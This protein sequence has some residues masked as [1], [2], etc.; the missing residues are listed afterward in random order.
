[1]ARLA[2]N[3]GPQCLSRGFRLKL[4]CDKVFPCVSCVKR[5]LAAICPDGCLTTGQG[6]RYDSSPSSPRLEPPC[7][8]QPLFTAL[9]WHPP[10]S[11]TRKLRSC[12]IEFGLSRVRITIH[13][14]HQPTYRLSSDALR[15]AYAKLDSGPHPLLTEELLSLKSPLQRDV[16]SGGTGSLHHQPTPDKQDS[17]VEAL[18]SLSLRDK[19]SM[20]YFGQTASS[21][22]SS[23]EFATYSG[24]N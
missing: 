23:H 1:M 14:Y 2:I 4:R 24:I 20:N 12:R 16:P 8:Y 15:D 18:G 19:G 7:E 3:Q 6:N 21:W 13:H 22:V 11:C 10:K 17:M 5:G 9:S